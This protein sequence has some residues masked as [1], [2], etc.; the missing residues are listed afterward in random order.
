M[1]WKMNWWIIFNRYVCFG[2]MAVLLVGL[3]DVART[4]LTIP[5][6]GRRLGN[7]TYLKPV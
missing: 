7:T 2:E 5:A 1:E 3:G 6:L 4:E